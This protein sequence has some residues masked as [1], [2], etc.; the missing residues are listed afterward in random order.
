LT[1]KNRSEVELERKRNE[2][3]C[4]DMEGMGKEKQ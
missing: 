1:Y 3:C 2:E 4:I